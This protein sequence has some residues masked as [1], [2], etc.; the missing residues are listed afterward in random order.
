MIDSVSLP[1]SRVRVTVVLLVLLSCMICFGLLSTNSPNNIW[2]ADNLI[3]GEN[4]NGKWLSLANGTRDVVVVLG[5]ENLEMKE[6]LAYEG[7]VVWW[8]NKPCPNENLR[9]VRESWGYFLYL[10]DTDP[11]KPVRNHTVFLHGH[12]ANTFHQRG[13]PSKLIHEAVECARKTNR[14]TSLTHAQLKTYWEETGPPYIKLWNDHFRNWRP[15][16]GPALIHYCCAQFVLPLHIMNRV[17]IHIYKHALEMNANIETADSFFWEQV[18]HFMFFEPEMI[19]PYEYQCQP[20]YS[21]A[22]VGI[23][24]PYTEGQMGV[25]GPPAANDKKDFLIVVGTQYA[26]DLNAVEYLQRKGYR[27]WLRSPQMCGGR[28]HP[29]CREATG[30]FSY[31]VDPEK[32][33]ADFIVFIKGFRGTTVAEHDTFD[34]ELEFAMKCAKQSKRFTPIGTRYNIKLAHEQVRK[35]IKYSVTFCWNR[36]FGNISNGRLEINHLPTPYFGS[37][38]IVPKELILNT[39]QRIWERAY[40]CST[41]ASWSML[42]SEAFEYFYH[43]LFGAGL[44]MGAKEGECNS[45]KLPQDIND[46]AWER[47]STA[48]QEISPIVWRK[49]LK[50][51][52]HLLFVIIPLAVVPVVGYFYF[53][54]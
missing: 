27:V 2:L 52:Q 51:D 3:T 44:T 7:Y 23:Q 34:R 46:F 5:G 26:S 50:F 20:K 8:R 24:K 16:T 6:W 21:S 39:D 15:I 35:K 33:I 11:A 31:M 49:V 54:R 19:N 9:A 14:Y 28:L 53:R 40:E 12:E 45:A 25:W 18:F 30:Y 41:V 48:V 4:S 29:R 32:P 22:L 42:D 17:P 47:P 43:F 36:A 10:S 13:L 38:F 37:Q 1:N